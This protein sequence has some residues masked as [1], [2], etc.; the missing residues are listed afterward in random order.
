MVMR[1]HPYTAT[2]IN[3]G[4][5]F[6]NDTKDINISDIKVGLYPDSNGELHFTDDWVK[7]ELGRES[8]TLKELYTRVKGI[9]YKDGKL[10]L[11][12][13]S[14]SRSYS[15]EEIIGNCRRWKSNLL[16]GS[17]HW[18]GRVETD[19]SNCANI[20]SMDRPNG[21]NS[22]WSVDRFLSQLNNINDCRDP[23]PLTFYEK[24]IDPNTGEW[25]WWD[26]PGVELVIPPIEDPYKAAMIFT[27]L[28]FSSYNSPEPII[29]RLFD[30]TANKELT[31]VSVV[32]ENKQP[33]LYPVHLN[34]FG[35]LSDTTECFS[36][37]GCGCV[38]VDC[39]DGDQS[40]GVN[41]SDTGRKITKK[42]AP[43][44]HLI[45][46][47]FHVLNYHANHWERTFGLT[48]DGNSMSKSSMDVVVYD[49]NPASKFDKKHGTSDFNNVDEIRVEFDSPML[50][51]N[52]SIS[53][54]PSRNVNVWW[55]NKTTNGFTIKSEL[56]IIG[57]VDWTIINKPGA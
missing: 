41:L 55:Q 28:A 2:G 31:R 27:K 13:S 30:H 32:Q 36:E 39:I 23:T 37:E 24:T 53:L 12:D 34:Y 14:I 4:R 49:I 15:F 22:L 17:L 10:F 47:Q 44:S 57:S 42:F 1:K 38:E 52:Y 54:S 43:G 19:H 25:R 5:P 6:P 56:P 3:F 18:M 21:A 20:P 29:F 46:V 45:K 8:I 26:V 9:H 50:S 7:N 11:K 35:T 51:T 16:N 33:V 40:C 48:V